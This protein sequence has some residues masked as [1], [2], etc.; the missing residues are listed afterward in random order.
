MP[1]AML[2][3]I[4]YEICSVLAN[5]L[6]LWVEQFA[7]SLEHAPVNRIHSSAQ[8][9]VQSMVRMG[10]YKNLSIYGDD[11]PKAVPIRAKERL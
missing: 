5:D 7:D 11:L 10:V 8:Y 4:E 6:M 3:Q 9:L 1:Q 2:R